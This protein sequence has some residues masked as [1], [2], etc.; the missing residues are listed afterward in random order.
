MKITKHAHRGN[1][2][3]LAMHTYTIIFKTRSWSLLLTSLILRIFFRIL[4][5]TESMIKFFSILKRFLFLFLFYQMLD[6]Q[7]TNY[8]NNF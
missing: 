7:E 8:L 2:N 5:N 4:I 1:N 6:F 3:N